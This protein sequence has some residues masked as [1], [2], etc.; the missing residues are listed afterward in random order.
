MVFACEEA[1]GEV[2]VVVDVLRYLTTMI[3]RLVKPL[4]KDPKRDPKDIIVHLF[5]NSMVQKP[6]FPALYAIQGNVV[7]LLF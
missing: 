1:E 6:A 7:F 4:K 3:W 2:I 5:P